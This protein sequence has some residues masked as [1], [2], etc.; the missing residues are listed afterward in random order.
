MRWK[1]MIV[2]Q[3]MKKRVAMPEITIKYD[4]QSVEVFYV[5]R[6]GVKSELAYVDKHTS[7]GDMAQG[8][9]ELAAALNASVS[10]EEE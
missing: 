1:I 5:S 7:M 2:W 4:D 10:M 9:Y 8:F 6:Q 3:L